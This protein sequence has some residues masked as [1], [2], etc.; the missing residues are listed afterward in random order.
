[1]DM[2]PIKSTQDVI[3]CDLLKPTVQ[4]Y[5]D[6]CHVNLCLSCIGKHISDDYDKHK[7]HAFSALLDIYKEKRKVIT[8]DTEELENILSPTYDG[9]ATELETQIANL[10]GEYDKL[11]TYVL[12]QGEEWHRQI[13][14]I[15]DKM[16]AEI[17]D[18]KVKHMSILKEHL[19]EIKKEVIRLQGWVPINLCV[20]SSGDLLVTMHKDD[21]TQSKIVR[22]SNYKEKQ[23]IQ[24]D[25]K[26]QSLFLGTNSIKYITENRNLDICIADWEVF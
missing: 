10:D 23:T 8:K 9:I 12:N 19:D 4:K 15:M 7:G 21:E 6:F 5:C 14:I 24:F 26:G 25:D 17:E 16:K 18:I 22:Y 20:T 1:L 11:I 2:D 13:K 3:R